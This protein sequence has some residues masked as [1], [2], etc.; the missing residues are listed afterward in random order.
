MDSQR[1]RAILLDVQDHLSDEDR[2]RLHFYLGG[3]VPRRIRDDPTLKGTLNLME[4]LFD[5]GK[6]SE[7]DFT[8][9]I[10][11]FDQIHCINAVRLLKGN[12]I[13]SFINSYYF[14]FIQSI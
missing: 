1:F 8:F 3:V 5:Q 4:S 11:A 13:F 7:Q 6:I 9:L 10:N 2:Q 12:F 14:L